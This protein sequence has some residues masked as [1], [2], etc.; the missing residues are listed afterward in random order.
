MGNRHPSIAPYET[1]SA[2]DGPIV[3]AVGNDGQFRTLCR[4]LGDEEL[5]D[6]ARFATNGDRVT[7]RDALVGALEPRLRSASASSW[8]DLLR[9]D[10]IPCGVLHDVA[11]AFAYA[12]TVDLA[13]VAP[14]T[15]RDGLEADTVANPRGMSL[16]AIRYDLAQAPVLQHTGDI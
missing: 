5:A 11:E 14:L 7:N 15:R 4:S 3:I 1:L 8:V 10:G 16:A 6:D 12:R 13:P 2:S 9:R